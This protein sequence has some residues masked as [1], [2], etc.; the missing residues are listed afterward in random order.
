M[1]SPVPASAPSVSVAV[2]GPSVTLV[3]AGP[4]DPDL[5]TV[6]GLK[7]LRSA[8]AVLYDALSSDALLA[9]VPAHA[10]RIYVGKRCGRHALK[11]P[12]INALLIA[13]ARRHG[14]VVRLKGGDPFVFGRGGEEV[15][16]LHRAGIP[17]RVIPG[18]SSAIAAPALAGV[19]LTHRGVSRGFWVL[20]ATTK[21]HTLPPDIEAAARSGATVVILMGTRCIAQI[22][23][24]FSAHRAAET[25][26]ALLQNASLP[27]ARRT[28]A[29]VGA[30]GSLV[31]AA[32][33]REPG[34]LVIGEVV[35]ALPYDWMS[36]NASARSSG[37]FAL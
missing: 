5:L 11:Q 32:E 14:H 27:N 7:A 6:G 21:D 4:G 22:A 34:V 25:P 16:A 37:V 30:P 29:T 33:T 17:A 35:E 13:T 24:V 10:P 23:K 31:R 26:F 8:D 2:A 28:V 15:A 20:T 3:G 12:D 1:S 19:P 9:E 18:V 36:A